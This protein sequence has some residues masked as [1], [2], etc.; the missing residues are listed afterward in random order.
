M[1]ALPIFLSLFPNILMADDIPLSSDVTA[2]TMYPSG[3]SI[4]REVPFSASAGQHDLI[5]T[6]LPRDT[7]LETVRVSVVGAAMGSVTVRNDFVP[8]RG[9]DTDAAIKAAEAK[10][11]RLE[12]ALR[13]GRAGAET[14]RLEEKAA[15][16][17]MAFLQKLGE[18][19]GIEQLGVA[20][21]RDLVDM[22]GDETLTAAK[23]AQNARIRA[24]AAKRDLKGLREELDNARLALKSLVPEVEARAMLAVAV[25]GQEVLEG[26]LTITYNIWG[27]NWQPIYDVKLDRASGALEFERGAFVSQ[28]S[29]ENWSDID[30]TLSTVRPSERTAPGILHPWYRRIEDPDQFEKRSTA[31]SLGGVLEMSEAVMPAPM[32]AEEDAIAAAA[33]RSKKLGDES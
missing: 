8:P 16:A 31:Q 30:L 6:D 18:G 29:G 7:P 21:L 26:S 2:V 14:I 9:T 23:A 15:D 17:R 28:S 19:E 10:I 22:I 27:A 33:L 11:K 24:D 12:Q 13:T 32:G 1:R 25:S 3:A 4:T 20:A 5:L